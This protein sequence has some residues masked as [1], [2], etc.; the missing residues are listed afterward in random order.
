LKLTEEQSRE[1]FDLVE[2]DSFKTL[3]N[4]VLPQFT[5]KMVD[6]MLSVDFNKNAQELLVERARLDG[7]LKLA[8]DI[9]ELK[10]YFRK[11]STNQ[12]KNA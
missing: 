10:T 8:N 12:R 6:R 4:I 1:M 11:V 3:I 2:G 7:A 9:K 5:Q